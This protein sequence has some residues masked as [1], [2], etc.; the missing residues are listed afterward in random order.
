MRK[1]NKDKIKN[2]VVTSAMIVGVTS[3]ILV[4]G[5]IK[6]GEEVVSD[7]FSLTNLIINPNIGEDIITDQA[8]LKF[9]SVPSRKKENLISAIESGALFINDLE[10]TGKSTFEDNISN[11]SVALCYNQVEVVDNSIVESFT[12]VDEES[13][14]YVIR[15]NYDILKSLTDVE[16][17]LVEQMDLLTDNVLDKVQHS[18]TD[19]I[20]TGKIFNKVYK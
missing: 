1:I 4:A 7:E 19:E 10:V 18:S 6:V 5:N 9:I 16:V 2:L 20:V 11:D 14:Y 3:C 15:H 8:T 17:T 12:V 13:N